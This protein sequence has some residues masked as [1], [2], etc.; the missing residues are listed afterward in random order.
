MTSLEELLKPGELWVQKRTPHGHLVK[1]IAWGLTE[2]VA[3]VEGELLRKELPWFV[4]N[5]E[6]EGANHANT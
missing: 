2:V 4:T 6:K 3:N 5:F 1:V